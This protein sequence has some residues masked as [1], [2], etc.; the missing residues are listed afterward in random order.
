MLRFWTRG[1]ALAVG[2]A[3]AA[4]AQAPVQ[5]AA[6]TPAAAPEAAPPQTAADREAARLLSISAWAK[7]TG[8]SREQVQERVFA[9]IIA[10]NQ[11]DAEKNHDAA[12]AIGQK[13][14]AAAKSGD[15]Q[16]AKKLRTVAELFAECAKENRHFLSAYKVGDMKGAKDALNR[17]R[18]YDERIAETAGQ[19]VPRSWYAHE[20]MVATMGMTGEEIKRGFEQQFPGPATAAASG[21]QA[22]K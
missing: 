7:K 13:A 12:V 16:G 5:P 2:F 3:V 15:A 10:G 11:S 21:G 20:L 18:V 4:A 9:P 1:V 14:D 17:L 8:A 19:R 22:Q 6:A